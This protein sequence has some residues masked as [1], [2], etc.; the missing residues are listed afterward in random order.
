MKT[1][2]IKPSA[3]Y[4]NFAK[5]ES[6]DAQIMDSIKPNGVDIFD[7][8][9]CHASMP[10]VISFNSSSSV[11][12]IYS[13]I[14]GRIKEGNDQIIAIALDASGLRTVKSW[15]L[16]RAGVSDILHWEKPAVA[17][18]MVASRIKRWHSV[19][20]LINSSIVKNS[21]IGKS[22]IWKSVLREIVELSVYTSVPVLILGESGT[23]KELISKLIHTLDTRKTKGNLVLVDCTTIVSDLSGSEF[24]GHEKGSYTNAISARDGAFALADKGTLFLD[25][26][27]ELPLNL[28]P[29]LLRVIQEG[30]YKKIGSNMWKETE[31]RLVSATNRNMLKEIEKGHFRQD[32]YYRISGW[33]CHLPPLRERRED[34]PLLVNHFLKKCLKVEELPPIDNLVYDFLLT[35]D[36]PGNIRELHQLVNR[37]AMRYVGNGPISV[38][39]IPE[40]DRPFPDF[41]KKDSEKDDMETFIRRA[42]LQG[43]NLKDIKESAAET[44]IDLVIREENGNLQ[45]A[46]SKLGVTDRALQL[47][48]ASSSNK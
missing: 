23:G 38:G 15:H 13:F 26:I 48:K 43:M 36:Y 44:A 21:L 19:D 45:K 9:D 14:E 8:N 3:W 28:Q 34:I 39:T 32:L 4:Y 2:Y 46:A 20:S 18:E 35:R 24:F 37:I 40:S 5:E 7:W 31:F 17:A 33:I 6:N 16:L 11:E 27:G 30:T 29:E 1:T 42:L 12:E 10:G 22:R 25:E 41:H 47:R